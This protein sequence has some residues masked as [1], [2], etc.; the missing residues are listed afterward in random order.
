M[1]AHRKPDVF[2]VIA[3]GQR[4]QRAAAAKRRDHLVTS[5]GIG[6]RRPEL[7]SHPLP[8]LSDPHVH[9]PTRHPTGEP[10]TPA[11]PDCHSTKQ[12]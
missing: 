12:Q 2:G 5:D 8:E 3:V 9:L 11:L 6:M 10:A 4:R 7:A 1:L